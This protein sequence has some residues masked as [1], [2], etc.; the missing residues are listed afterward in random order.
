MGISLTAE[1][2]HPGAEAAGRY[3][4][5]H[6]DQVLNYS[7]YVTEEILDSSHAVIVENRLACWHGRAKRL[8]RFGAALLGFL[9]FLSQGAVPSRLPMR[10]VGTWQHRD[11]A[12]QGYQGPRH[13]EDGGQQHP[14]P[15]QQPW[16]ALPPT[17]ALPEPSDQGRASVNGA[18]IHYARFGRGEPVIFLHGGLANSNYWGNQIQ[19]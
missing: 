18:A 2:S 14:K 6:A 7:D 17:P 9:P 12:A 5:V 16:L 4:Y 3:C 13:R 8:L 19:R 11:V 15:Q 1:R 10:G